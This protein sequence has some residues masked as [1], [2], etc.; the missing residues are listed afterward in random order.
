MARNS[1]RRGLLLLGFLIVLTFTTTPFPESAQAID[2]GQTTPGNNPPPDVGAVVLTDATFAGFGPYTC[3]SGRHKSEPVGEGYILKV[4]GKCSD[5]AAL[6]LI[7]ARV[8]SVSFPDGEIRLDFKIVSGHDRARFNLGFRVQPDYADYQVVVTPA[9]NSAS[10]FGNSNDPLAFRQD[11][12]GVMSRDDWNTLAVRA[13][14]SELWVLLNDQL[15]LQG[16]DPTYDRGVTVF[17]LRRLGDVNDEP[18][19]AAVIRNLRISALANSDP[20]QS[21]RLQVPAANP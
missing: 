12:S 11:L 18:E 5:T 13:R 14:G 20:E 7:G 4:T 6:P 8:S 19:T 15:V 21:P 16:N 10:L 1:S 3:P 17:G 2:T 9:L